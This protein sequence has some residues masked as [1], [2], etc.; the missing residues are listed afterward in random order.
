MKDDCRDSFLMEFMYLGIGCAVCCCCILILFYLNQKKG[1]GGVAGGASSQSGPGRPLPAPELKKGVA[2]WYI[3][4]ITNPTRVSVQDGALKMVIVEKEHG[5]PSGCGIR[6]TPFNAFPAEAATLSYSVFLPGSP[7]KGGKLPGFCIGNSI[8]AC[9]NG[10]DWSTI[11]GSY[12][13]MWKDDTLIGYV[14]MALGNT[15]A[16]GKA[17]NPAF[18]AA[19]NLKGGTGIDVWA[20]DPFKLKFGGWNDISLSLKLNTPGASDGNMSLTVNG[21]T[22]RLEGVVWRKS[23]SVKINY[24][25]FV[26][27]AGGGDSSWSVPSTTYRLFKNIACSTTT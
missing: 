9:A 18:L 7:T 11:A 16:A 25:D 13:V 2:P 14:Y 27:F 5:M 15:Q 19:T 26:T 21:T 23:A 1:G 24:V 12:R 4:G 10:G 22:K 3:K 17:Q 8:S 20:K 6:A